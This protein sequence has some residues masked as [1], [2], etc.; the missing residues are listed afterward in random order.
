MSTEAAEDLRALLRGEI[1]PSELLVLALAR[2]L[3]DAMTD[4]EAVEIIQAADRRT[5]ADL[6]TALLEIRAERLRSRAP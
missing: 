4:E 6:R 1:T 2:K 3:F 5:V